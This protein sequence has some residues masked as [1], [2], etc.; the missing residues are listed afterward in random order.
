MRGTLE[1]LRERG[2]G[3]G[4]VVLRRVHVQRLGL[5]GLGVHEH[6]EVARV[7]VAIRVLTEGR[8]AVV[9]QRVVERVVRAQTLVGEAVQGRIRVHR[10]FLTK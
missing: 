6:G 3:R 1:A 9:V 2:G 7:Q 10:G 5:V 8:D 4:G